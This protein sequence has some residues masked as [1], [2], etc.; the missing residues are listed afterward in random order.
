[1]LAEVFQKLIDRTRAP[2]DIKTLE[3]LFGRRHRPPTKKQP[4]AGRSGYEVAQEV[5][6]SSWEVTVWRVRWGSVVLQVYDQAGRVL[7]GE[8]KALN[9]AGRGWGKGL[10]KLSEQL[11]L[12]AGDGGALSGQPAGRACGVSGR[13]AV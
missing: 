10:G 12:R 9:T 3:T 5:E 7:R 13:G 2:L 1:M 11:E 6:A 8:V 4:R